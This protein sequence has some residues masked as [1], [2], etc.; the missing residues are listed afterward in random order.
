MSQIE[1][2]RKV[3]TGQR[4]RK[5]GDRG[6]EESEN[7]DIRTCEISIRDIS[8]R[9]GPSDHTRSG[10]LNFPKAIFSRFGDLKVKERDKPVVP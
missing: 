8:I 3:P 7:L 1:A 4:H 6:I 5:I 10:P 2:I 9:S